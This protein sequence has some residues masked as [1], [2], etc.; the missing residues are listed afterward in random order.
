[1][2]KMI[3]CLAIL[4]MLA[5]MVSCKSTESGG[6]SDNTVPTKAAVTTTVAEISKDEKTTTVAETSK[7]E[8]TTTASN[9]AEKSK[10]TTKNDTS[11]NDETNSTLVLKEED[12]L[13]GAYVD[14]QGDVLNLRNEPSPTA[15]IIDTIPDQTQIDIYSCGKAGWY[16]T[17]YNGKSGYVSAVYIKEIQDYVP[18]E[19]TQELITDISELVG[20]WKYQIAPEGKNITVGATDNGIID[21]KSDG[22]YTYTDLDGN[23]HSGTVK[24][25]YDTLGGD[26]SVPFFAFY[27]GD[28]FFISC[29]CQQNN[30]NV[31]LIGNGGMGQLLSVNADFSAIAGEWEELNGDGRVFDISANGTYTVTYPNNSTEQG[32]IKIGNEIFSENSDGKWY[33]FYNSSGMA[34]IG[35]PKTDSGTVDEL[36]AGDFTLR[37]R[38]NDIVDQEQAEDERIA[39]KSEIAAA[40]MKDFNAIM[41]VLNALAQNMVQS[42][43]Y[44]ISHRA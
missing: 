20:Q 10:D 19:N 29:Y 40:R 44:T 12:R 28:K 23:T 2:R 3:S 8:K 42:C 41:A 26:Y 1:M 16:C 27:E 17:S 24:V 37:R 32:F 14:T 31:Y 21:V 38:K 34:W 18:Q 13:F 5:S 30:P 35:F 33:N 7:D 4:T 25:D 11:A 36:K 22:T 15:D 6:I 43:M 39:D 9:G